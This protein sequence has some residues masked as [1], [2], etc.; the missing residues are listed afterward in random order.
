MPLNGREKPE[1]ESWWMDPGATFVF[2]KRS[3]FRESIYI[4]IRYFEIDRIESRDGISRCNGIS[5]CKNARVSSLVLLG[6]P[7]SERKHTLCFLRRNLIARE[8]ERNRYHFHPS[9]RIKTGI[10]SWKNIDE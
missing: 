9:F 3:S 5:G 2:Q 4:Y 7:V 6:D 8:T 1:K 10:S